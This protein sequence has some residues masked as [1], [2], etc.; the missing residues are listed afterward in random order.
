MPPS[1]GPGL[2]LVQSHVALLRL[3]LRFNAPPG[4]A[5][6]GQRLQGS[7]LGSVGQIVAGLTAVQVTAVAAPV[8]F[9]GLPPAGWPHPL[10][11]EH[12]APRTLGSLRHR[13]LPPG[14]LRQL[15]AALL[16]LRR[17]P[18]PLPLDI[19]SVVDCVHHREVSGDLPD[20]VRHAASI[21]R[22]VLVMA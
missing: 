9:A 8:D 3:E 1:P 15:T 12:I 21:S 17:L 10:G 13:Y 18:V 6:V 22:T 19:F 5:H 20:I 16:Q 2:V 11:A 14:L 4:T 7:V